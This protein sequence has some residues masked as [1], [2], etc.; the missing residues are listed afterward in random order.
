MR[1]IKYIV[2]HCTATAGDAKVSSI[3]RYWKENLGWK[4]PGYHFIIDTTGKVSHIHPL[5]SPSNGVRGYNAN[6]IHIS[7]IGGIDENAKGKDTRT[8]EQYMVMSALVQS[9]KAVHPDAKIMGH[10]DFPDVKKECP[11]FDAATFAKEIGV[12]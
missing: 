3:V 8:A 1:E 5:E 10:R 9:M 7:Y 11:S 4:N 12:A 2:L 6:S